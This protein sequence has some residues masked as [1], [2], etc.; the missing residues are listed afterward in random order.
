MLVDVCVIL[1]VY[2][3]EFLAFLSFA[4]CCFLAQ[5]DAE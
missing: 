5:I 2:E 4:A 3:H 1:S